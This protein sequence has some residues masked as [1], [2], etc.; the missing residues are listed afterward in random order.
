MAAIGLFFL[1]LG[2][3]NWINGIAWGKYAM[4]FGLAM[5]LV[6]LFQWFRDAISESQGGQYSKHID[7]SFRWSMG[8]FIFSEVM[9]FG[10]HCLVGHIRQSLPAACSPDAWRLVPRKTSH[11]QHLCGLQIRSL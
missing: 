8:W 9:F 1:L 4:F 3:G 11:L 5:F 6:V 10:G 7:I 2:A